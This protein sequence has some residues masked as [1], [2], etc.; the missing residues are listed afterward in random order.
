[1][2]SA[3]SADFARGDF[4]LSRSQRA[5][6]AGLQ[7]V[8]DVG[9]NAA[10]G[11]LF[12]LLDRDASSSGAAYD[13]DL[14]QLSPGASVALGAQQPAETH[15]FLN[16]MLSCP[17]FQGQTALVKEGGCAWARV[18]GH[19]VSQRATDGIPGFTGNN[20]T[21]QLGGEAGIAPDWLV[22]GSLAVQ[23]ST[24]SS[25]N[26]TSQGN[27]QSG[28]GGVGVK[29]QPGPWLVAL[30]VAGSYGS[31][32]TERSIALAGFAG[33][34]TASPVIESV[35]TR[36]RLARSF[37]QG[38]WYV[39]S[40]LDLD[41]IHT[42]APAFN[43]SGPAPI[44]LAVL[45]ANQTTF[46]GAPAIEVGRRIDLA[47]GKTLRPFVLAGV[48]FY[49]NSDWR[50]RASFAGA[51][52]AASSFTTT[53]PEGQVIGRAGAGVQFLGFRNFDFRLQYDGE[54][55]ANRS[56]NGGYLTGAVRF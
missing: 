41:L 7:S 1:M 44:G 40:Y 21:Y 30:A 48:S 10:F 28:Y 43:E 9:G 15:N 54:F 11:P 17:Q 25:S 20:V 8:W 26:A 42:H 24:F 27:G 29:W 36:V 12:A 45:A 35:A 46:V 23:T 34:A 3:T 19:A 56:S 4:S 49:S 39:R 37:D 51:P 13:R 31:F 52:S 14:D 47:D 16:A 33:I 53:I 5:V 6:A 2:L 55:G 22:T 32:S 50:V 18:I 38:E